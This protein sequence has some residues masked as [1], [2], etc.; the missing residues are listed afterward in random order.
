MD[1]CCRGSKKGFFL[2]RFGE[3]CFEKVKN[4]KEFL[5]GLVHKLMDQFFF[6]KVRR[7]VGL[8]WSKNFW[9]CVAFVWNFL[10]LEKRVEQPL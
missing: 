4:S 1:V 8:D 2:V 6:W 10:M 3:P 7:C 5:G 9:T